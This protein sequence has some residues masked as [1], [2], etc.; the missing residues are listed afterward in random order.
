MELR[1]TKEQLSSFKK[2]LSLEW[3][4]TNGLGGYASSTILNCHTRKY[5]GLL[6]SNLSEP[7][8]KFVL[9]SQLEDIFIK[10]ERAY[11]LSANQFAGALV[12]D[13]FSY[14]QE[15]EF[16]IHPYTIY[17]FGDTTI[18]KEI[19]M[20][21]QENTVLV[22][23]TAT[24]SGETGRLKIKPLAAYRHFH[25][26]RRKNSG[27]NVQVSDCRIGKQCHFLEK[28]PNL[29]LQ[30][31]TDFNY[32]NE[33]VWYENFE[34]AVEKNR[35]YDH[36]EDLLSI[37]E[38]TVSLTE[39]QSVILSCGTEEQEGSLAAK[40]RKEIARRNRKPN[41]GKKNRQTA[42]QKQLKKSAESFLT[43]SPR[44][45]KT[46]I[47]AGYHWF[48]EWGRDT[49]IALPGLTLYRGLE[50]ECLTIL[51]T[52]AEHEKNGLLPNYLAEKPEE[53]NYQS[54][55]AG[56]WFSWA[57][58][59]YYLQTKN[60]KSLAEKIWPT[61]KNIFTHYK[62]GTSYNIKMRD[63]GLLYAGSYE[64]ALTWMDAL[65]DR[66]PATPR[67]GALVEVNAL[68]FNFL[69]F[70]V[71][72]GKKLRDP[73]VEDIKPLIKPLIAAFRE[74]FWDKNIGYLKDAVNDDYQDFFIRPNQIFAVSL[75]YSPLTNK[76]SEITINT[77]KEHLLTPYGLKSLSSAS[78][79]H[80]KGKY[81]GGSYQR[82]IA[83]HN[84]TIW[85]WLLGAFTDALLKV[86]P[87]KKS[88]VA[89]LEPCFNALEFHLQEAGIGTIS[90][91]FDGDPPHQPR[92]CISQAWS[93]AEILRAICLL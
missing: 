85:P 29:F 78:D 31:D 34:Y 46:L 4:E 48:A 17:Q 83:Y 21:Y 57:V 89:I 40:W 81:E 77:V 20:P 68:W 8:G 15:A 55:D 16:K 74:T 50:D 92:G 41:T 42:L 58:Q 22:K 59:Q 30:I 18:I 91:I 36:L 49:C 12:G 80:Y 56:L 39:G 65:I 10:N 69:N 72:I 27:M 6:V 1:F 75:P 79:Q 47:T 90:E 54:V 33:T 45:G 5:H 88:V 3:L 61:L 64:L 14:Y 62:A 86:M 52:L 70:M 60:Y 63:N 7:A 93:V 24:N 73:I 9:L 51:E 43:I 71:E 87:D 28:M 19:L 44:L 84:G 76:M 37:G 2:A 35:G 26:L 67:Y 25:D 82:D 11:R 32:S 38:F 53:D 13:N 23:Y 66:Q